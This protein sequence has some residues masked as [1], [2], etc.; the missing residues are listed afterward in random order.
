[1]VGKMRAWRV[2][3]LILNFFGNAL[4]IYGLAGLIRDGSRLPVFLIGAVMTFACILM[5]ARPSPD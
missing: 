4:A 5:L 2:W 1:M 3:G